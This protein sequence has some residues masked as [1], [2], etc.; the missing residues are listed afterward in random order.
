MRCQ[1]LRRALASRTKNYQSLDLIDLTNQLL[2]FKFHN[3][4]FES[5]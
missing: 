3:L 4:D 2:E 5:F 1:P